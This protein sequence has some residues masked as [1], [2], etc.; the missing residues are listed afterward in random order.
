MKLYKLYNPEVPDSVIRYFGG[1]ADL[2]EACRN[3]LRVQRDEHIAQEINVQTDKA[4][5]VGTLNGEPQITV[6]RT[7]GITAR[8]ALKE[9]DGV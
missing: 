7:F 1:L 9:E 6:L 8:G 4:G 3:L 5:V 2:K